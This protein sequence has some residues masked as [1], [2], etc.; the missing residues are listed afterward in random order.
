VHPQKIQPMTNWPIPK[1]IKSLRGFL[2]LTGYYQK[3]FKNYARIAIPLTS[4][5]KKNSFVWNVEATLAFPFL[6]HAV[7]STP[8]L[9]TPDFGKTFIVKCDAYVKELE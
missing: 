4:L 6:K 5:L 7:Y 3:K 2:G 9:A 1:I 8:I